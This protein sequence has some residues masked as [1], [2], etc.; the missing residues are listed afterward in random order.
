M[1]RLKG[2]DEVAKA[3][4]IRC[5]QVWQAIMKNLDFTLRQKATGG[6]SACCTMTWLRPLGMERPFCA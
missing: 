2:G 5:C 1:R 3:G 4:S 6:I